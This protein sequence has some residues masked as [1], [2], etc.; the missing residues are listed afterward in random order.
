MKTRIYWA[1]QH[2]SQHVSKCRFKFKCW[3]LSRRVEF[4]EWR[5]GL[6]ALALPSQQ[7]PVQ[8]WPQV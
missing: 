4:L 7:A 3:W 2:A 6:D 1:I 5:I 8:E